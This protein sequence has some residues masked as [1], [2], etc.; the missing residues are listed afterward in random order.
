MNLNQ[1]ENCLITSLS[2]AEALPMDLHQ[3]KVLRI[4]SP[5]FEFHANIH[6]GMNDLFWGRGRGWKT[7]Y[8]FEN[9]F[10]H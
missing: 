3:G 10:L 9:Q 7:F 2:V 5:E 4:C 6:I 1:K 8:G